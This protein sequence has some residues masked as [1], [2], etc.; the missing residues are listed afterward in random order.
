MN[1]LINAIN[2]IYYSVINDISINVFNKEIKFDL[3]L[4]DIGNISSHIMRFKNV[5]SFLWIEKPKDSKFYSFPKCEYYELTS[6]VLKKIHINTDDDWF[7]QYLMEYN[8][9]IEIWDTA[10]LIRATELLIDNE[11]FLISQ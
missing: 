1:D 9:V 6:I 5:E 3:T 7:K 2:S 10:L 11:L 8:V 4:H